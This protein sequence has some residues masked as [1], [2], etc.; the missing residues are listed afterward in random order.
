[1]KKYLLYLG[2]SLSL[3]VLSL[4][5]F[6][7]SLWIMTNHQESINAIE[8]TNKCFNFEL[9]SESD[10][11]KLENAYPISDAAGSKL[12]PYTFKIT[13]TCDWHAYY[14]INLETMSK[15]TIDNKFI[16]TSLDNKNP[17]I[18]SSYSKTDT[19]LKDSKESETLITGYLPAGGSASFELR[20]WLDYDTTI[21]DI[22]NDGSDKWIGKIVIVS[23]LVEE[24]EILARCQKNG[25]DLIDEGECRK[26]YVKVNNLIATTFNHT[27][28][29]H[30]TENTDGSFKA[31]AASETFASDSAKLYL[32]E[33]QL[34]D[35]KYFYSINILSMTETFGHKTDKILEFT[36]YTKKDGNDYWPR[37]YQIYS[38]D[39]TGVY[40]GTFKARADTDKFYIESYEWTEFTFQDAMGID[41]TLMFGEGNEP[42]KAWC[43]KYLTNYIEYNSEGTLMSLKEIGEPI[44][45][46]YY[47]TISLK[48]DLIN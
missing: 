9:T 45:T 8:T 28:R 11:I 25:G 31:S 5:G 41:L 7:Y 39:D 37:L 46:A 44:K 23:N 14:K 30:V 4:L 42:D 48:L 34:T 3:I 20:L 22:K 38:L 2:I 15:S 13:N 36:R 47:D 10:S 17:R 12:S 24:D 18:I 16:K 19:I 6:S 32:I 29:Y 1:M 43:D 33:N 27:N 40:T 26:Y 21:N 35:H